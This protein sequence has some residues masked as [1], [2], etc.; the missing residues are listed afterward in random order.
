MNYKYQLVMAGASSNCRI[1]FFWGGPA[2]EIS[3]ASH[4]EGK[5]TSKS[6]VVLWMVRSKSGVKTS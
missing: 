4:D 3:V 6:D 5:V 2:D 1:R